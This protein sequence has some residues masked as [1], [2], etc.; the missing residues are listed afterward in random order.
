MSGVRLRAGQV[1]SAN[2]EAACRDPRRYPDPDTFDPTR[3]S[4]RDLAFGAGAHYCIGAHVAKLGLRVALGT[5]TQRFPAMT[6]AGE[7]ADV[8][9]DF[10]G[11]QGVVSLPVHPGAHD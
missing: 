8:C 2:L 1:V 11:F 3:P 6:V 10:D 9:W 5:L 7:P 4:G